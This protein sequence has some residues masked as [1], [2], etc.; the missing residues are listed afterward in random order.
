MQY[1]EKVMQHFMHPHN[2]GVIENPD[3]YGKVGNP[4]CEDIMEIFI[5]VDNDIITDV[6]FRTFGCASAI[7]SSS[8]STDMIIGKTVEEA[9][10]LTNKQVVDELG[11]LPA[12][13]M[14]CSVLA[15]EAI[16][17]AIEDYLS[18]RDG[19]KTEKAE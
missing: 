10:K 16:K 2:V 4:S 18:K 13:K 17:M 1:T 19:K 11:G 3:G 8:I 14:H 12:V 9:L 6:K 7:A 15:E 5:K